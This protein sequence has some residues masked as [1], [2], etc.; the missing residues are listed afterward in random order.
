MRASSL[1]L[2]VFIAVGLA[3]IANAQV[4]PLPAKDQ[5]VI[6]AKLGP[7]VVGQALA[8]KPLPDPS[9]YFPL[10][11]KV[12]S[13]QATAGSKSG[14]T[15]DLDVAKGKRPN[16][17]PAWRFELAPGLLGFLHQTKSGDLVMPAMADMD[18]G[19]VVV[20]TPPNPFFIK[21]MKPG[22]TRTESQ[23]VSVDSLDDPSDQRYSG[24]LE[25]SF[26]Y[27]GTYRVSVPAGTYDAVLLRH[28]FKGKIGPADT[29]DLAYYL[30][31]PGVGIVAMITQEDIEAFWLLHVDTSTGKVLSASSSP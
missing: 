7:G 16:G 24:K 8:S 23:S 14:Q 1:A 30:L 11:E 6:D 19:L 28:G 29:T 21:G 3:P 27:V 10:E 13:Y 26:T 17:T 20:M 25:N 15:V 2:L 5:K 9:V 12:R 18:E 4:I 22:A 31:A